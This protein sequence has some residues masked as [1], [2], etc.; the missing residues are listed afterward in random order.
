[1]NPT[2]DR[3]L[4]TSRPGAG[5]PP[6]RYAG[7]AITRGGFPRVGFTELALVKLVVVEYDAVWIPVLDLA[8][9]R[10]TVVRFL[11]ARVTVRR[12]AILRT[13]VVEYTSAGCFLREYVML[14]YLQ[15]EYTPYG[16]DWAEHT[17]LASAV[18]WRAW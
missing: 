8:T 1:M 14:K 17:A 10:V 6:V 18:A 13:T 11:V 2:N 15:E 5:L 7:P 9:L 16:Y 4:V 12:V 3:R